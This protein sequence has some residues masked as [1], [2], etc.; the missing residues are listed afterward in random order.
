MRRAL[1]AGRRSDEEIMNSK[2]RRGKVTL[3]D[4]FGDKQT[5]VIYSYMF[6]PQREQPCPMCT[7]FM[8]TWEGETARCRA[9]HRLRI[10]GAL[11]DRAAD[12][13]EA[14]ARLDAAQDLFRSIRRLHARLC[15]RRRC[16]RA[17]LQRVHAPRRHHPPFLVRRDGTARPPIP[18]RIRAARPILI[19]SGPSSTP[20]RK[21]VAPTGIR[22]EYWAARSELRRPN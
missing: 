12:R 18:A 20:R 19:R 10:R 5:L 22:V 2:A 11:A 21:V 8:S 6:G 4:L 13:G 3:A 1:A 7:S 14:G 15:Q 16:R 9:A 17:R